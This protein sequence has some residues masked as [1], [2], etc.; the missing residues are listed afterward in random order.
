MHVTLS[1]SVKENIYM[2]CLVEEFGIY[3]V[4]QLP[5]L[6]WKVVEPIES[7]CKVQSEGKM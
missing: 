4:L 6:G 2:V 3:P 1:F 7:K 5:S